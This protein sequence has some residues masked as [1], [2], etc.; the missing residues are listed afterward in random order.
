MYDNSETISCKEFFSRFESTNPQ[1]RKSAEDAVNSYTRMKMREDGF[2]R[3]ILPPVP[4]TDSDL[5]RQ[6]DTP[7]PVI[8]IDKEPNT[9]PAVNIPFHAQPEIKF[10]KGPR[11]SVMF[12]R[13]ATEKFVADTDADLRTWNMDIRQIISDNA[14]KDMLATEDGNAIATVNTILG[15]IDTAVTETGT[16]QYRTVAGGISRDSFN[17][18]LKILPQTPAHLETATVLVNNVFVKDLQ[19]W[20]YDE[21]G[22]EMS[23]EILRSG[24]G[25]RSILNTRLVVTIKRQL[26]A[27]DEAYFFAEP[28]FFGKFFELVP[29]TMHIKREAFMIEFFAY[30]TI[31]SAIANAAA[32]ARA[33]FV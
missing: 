23:E 16:V 25:E 12:S 22:G 1:M 2:W 29:P 11:Y 14:V 13:I 24:F 30:E 17:D 3:K 9:P 20:G 10:I 28:K 27:D 5:D 21:V 32:V 18:A 15:T 6:V 8:I 19:K 31:G 33:K 7:L 4:V 26:V